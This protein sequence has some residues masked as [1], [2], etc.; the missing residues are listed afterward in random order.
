[1]SGLVASAEICSDVSQR[2]DV[3]TAAMRK[4]YL[5]GFLSVAQ[6]VITIQSEPLLI[7]DARRLLQLSHCLS[8]AK[9]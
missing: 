2:H 5:S 7:K 4:L 9:E 8:S 1:M 6:T 3:R